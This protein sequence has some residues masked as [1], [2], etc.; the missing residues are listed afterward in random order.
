MIIANPERGLQKYSDS[1]STLGQ[2]TLNN[3]RNSS[4]R[5]TVIYRVY[6]LSSFLTTN[7]SQ[8]FLN[9]ITT[10]FTRVRNAGMKMIVRFAYNS[11]E[12]LQA[13]PL[14]AQIINHIN[15]VAPILNA[16][17]DVVFS[18]QAGWI[19]T[20]GEWY[21]TSGSTEFGDK[22][23]ISTVQWQNRMDILNLMLTSCPELF[24]QVRYPAIKRRLTANQ[25]RVGFYNDA[26]LNS[27]GDMGTYSISGQFTNPAGTTDYNYIAGQTLLVPMTGES[28]GINAPRTDGSNAIVEL[29]ALNFH[30]LNRDYFP[31]VWTNWIA[32]GHYNEIVERLGYRFSL[33]DKSFT[34]NGSTVSFNLTVLNDGFSSAFKSRNVELVLVSPTS[35]IVHIIN[36]DVR[37]WQGSVALTG[38]I[39]NIAPG[40][41]NAFLRLPDTLLPTNGKYSI[42]FVNL[43]YNEVNGL[44]DLA[45][46]FTISG[47]TKPNPPVVSNLTFRQGEVVQPLAVQGQNIKFY[48]LGTPV[49]S[50]TPNTSQVGVTTIG[51]SQTV[52]GIESD[53]VNMTITVTAVRMTLNSNR[54]VLVDN[55]ADGS[56]S[57]SYTK[58]GVT[59]TLN[60]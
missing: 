27:W 51:V 10:D 6:Y 48:V 4:D 39:Q 56:F 23:A 50:F 40:T 47:A 45:T 49:T 22:G 15:Q 52:N 38:T 29:N 59:T 17:K 36:T 14:K 7:I 21:Y 42:R 11:S 55:I 20:W 44:N 26:F 57:L 1:R 16:N 8:T 25:N 41:Y 28:N 54:T 58:N 3:L 19:G 5:I 12:S 35:T 13:Q 18:Y 33:V 60:F 32:S 30:T 37:T 53:I 46:Q 24:V 31:Q 34:A 43:P 2:T 9:Q